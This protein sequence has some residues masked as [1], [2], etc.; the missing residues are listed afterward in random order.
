LAA[1]AVSGSVS[2]PD[3]G[4]A[5]VFSVKSFIACMAAG[6]IA[7]GAARA[8]ET[9][10]VT[11]DDKGLT[12]R[13]PDEAVKLEIGGRL[14]YD[15]GT[16]RVRDFRFPERLD[17]RD[18]MRRARLEAAFSIRDRLEIAFGYDFADR[19][20]PIKD[21]LVAFTALDPVI[22]SAGNMKEP[23][24]L[25]QLT[26]S[27]NTLFVERSL[28]DAFA[29]SRNTGFAVGGA[30]EN[31]TLTAGIFG[32]NINS[33]VRHE[34]TAATARLTFAP[35]RTDDQVVHLGLAG[36]WRRLPRTGFDFGYDTGP[37]TS[38]FRTSL[39][40]TD[41]IDRASGVGR[42]GLEAAWKAG[43]LLLQGE[44]VWSSV[45]RLDARPTA[46]FEGGYVQAGW[47]LNGDGRT[48]T[49]SPSSGTTF[50]V[51][52]SPKL[53]EGERLTQ[54]GIGLWEIGARVSFI[55]LTDA[56]APRGGSADVVGGRELNY[57]AALNWYP[58]PNVKVMANYV[59]AVALNSPTVERRVDAD[60]FVGRVQLYW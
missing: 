50:A 1:P 28:A 20:Q 22:V 52:G 57:S 10:P 27:N 4:G 36:G 14:N 47:V 56:F 11:I 40:D 18:D 55:D 13:S 44:Y 42:I 38:L 60:I 19:R 24:S 7:A 6:I 41:T 5:F 53:K 39:V 34:G 51:F 8:E 9:K 29:P 25:D 54:G 31:W 21:A 48:Y 2:A 3:G 12:F 37:E 17:D 58:D 59:R 43:P 23:F 35:V 16:A 33:G 49:L 32:G 15:F 30:W 45:D 46:R 26:S